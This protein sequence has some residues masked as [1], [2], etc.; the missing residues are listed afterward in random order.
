MRVSVCLRVTDTLGPILMLMGAVEL[1]LMLCF[2]FLLVRGP[3]TSRR[4]G[5]FDVN[6][7]AAQVSVARCINCLTTWLKV[8]LFSFILI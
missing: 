8:C 3:V 1:M 4:N 5:V 6:G 2:C 7:S